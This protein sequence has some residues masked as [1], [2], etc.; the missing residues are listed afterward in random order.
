MPLSYAKE[1][2]CVSDVDSRLDRLQAP[3][4]DR[5]SSAPRFHGSPLETGVR[6]PWNGRRPIPHRSSS[7]DTSRPSPDSP[8]A[9]PQ[10][11]LQFVRYHLIA[12]SSFASSILIVTSPSLTCTHKLVLGRIP[13]SARQTLLA[14][15]QEDPM[16]PPT[17]AAPPGPRDLPQRG[18]PPDQSR[19]HRRLP[20]RA[21]PFRWS[22]STTFGP[23]GPRPFPS[24]CSLSGSELRHQSTGQRNRGHHRVGMSNDPINHRRK[25]VLLER[26]VRLPHSIC[27]RGSPARPQVQSIRYEAWRRIPLRLVARALRSRPAKRP[28]VLRPR[29]H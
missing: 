1:R 15:P 26:C 23:F 4:S 11:V 18:H 20:L 12:R 9:A 7:T 22:S 13:T 21:P 16:P 25:P 10:E 28:Q 3:S 14:M 19:H 27:R 8:T 6:R 29:N 24:P 5:A 2:C 17:P